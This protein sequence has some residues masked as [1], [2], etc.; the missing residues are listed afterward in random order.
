LI[1]KPSLESTSQSQNHPYIFRSHL[2]VEEAVHV[3]SRSDFDATKPSI[4]GQGHHTEDKL[5]GFFYKGGPHQGMGRDASRH[6]IK[7]I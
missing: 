2:Q 3:L 1:D 6:L 4:I 7:R 5:M